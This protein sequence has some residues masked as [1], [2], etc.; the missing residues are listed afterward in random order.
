V[1]WQYVDRDKQDSIPIFIQQPNQ[2]SER[3]YISK[4]N[5]YRYRTW[6]HYNRDSALALRSNNAR[7]QTPIH[8]IGFY[9]WSSDVETA[10]FWEIDEKHTFF[11]N[12]TKVTFDQCVILRGLDTV[13][14]FYSSGSHYRQEVEMKTDSFPIGIALESSILYKDFTF[15]ECDVKGGAYFVGSQFLGLASFESS[16][17]Q[18]P[19]PVYFNGV[20]WGDTVVMSEATFRSQV[21]F[22]SSVLPRYWDFS[23]V[24][25]DTLVDLTVTKLDSGQDSCQINLVGTDLNKVK[26]DYQ[27][28]RL[29]F[30]KGTATEEK[31]RMYETLLK[32]FETN[33]YRDSY[34][35]LDM[36]YRG[37]D[38]RTRADESGLLGHVWFRVAN[39]VDRTWWRYGY[40]KGRIFAWTGGLFGGFWL[41][42]FLFLGLLHEQVYPIPAVWRAHGGEVTDHKHY[43]LWGPQLVAFWRPAARSLFYSALYTG[44]VFFGLKMELDRMPFR[45]WLGTVY[46]FVQYIL[47]L[48]CLGYLANVVI[49]G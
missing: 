13:L 32:Q 33:G 3:W 1:G 15:T 4:S 19:V 23:Y 16:N 18:G 2:N 40:E 38:Y 46:L 36:E 14:E 30:P 27:K 17:F 43:I 31:R 48:A 11:F 10:H 49:T 42:N 21:D 8:V 22:D 24:T 26:L 29:F 44:F 25:L 35:L 28:Y 47:G 5:D 20:I 34:R 7:I 45:H 39:W 41:L 37:F 6:L 12:T 9:D